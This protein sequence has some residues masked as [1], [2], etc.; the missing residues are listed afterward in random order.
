MIVLIS[1]THSAIAC[2]Q[3]SAPVAVLLAAF[4]FRTAAQ[5]ANAF[6]KDGRFAHEVLWDI[7]VPFT[8]RLWR[9]HRDETLRRLSLDH[10]GLRTARH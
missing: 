5:S 8:L 6:W 7:E 2:R 10:L 1:R 4:F 3:P 9:V